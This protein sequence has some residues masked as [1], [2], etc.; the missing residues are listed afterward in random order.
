M[1]FK[2]FI[3]M[4]GAVPFSISYADIDRGKEAY[5]MGEYERAIAEFIPEADR[6]NTYALIKL[7]FMCENGW[8]IAKDFKKA[9]DYYKTAADAGNAEGYMSIAKLYAYGKGVEKNEELAKSNLLRAA[10]LGET[11]AY[12][13]LANTYNDIYAFGEKPLEALKWYLMAAEKNTAA[14]SRNGH[15]NPGIGRWFRLLSPEGVRLTRLSADTGNVYAQFNTG[16]RY[17]YGEGV[18][19]DYNVAEE[20]FF[21]AAEG[22]IVEAQKFVGEAHAMNNPIRTDNVFVDKWFTI[23]SLGGNRAARVFKNSLEDQMSQ[24]EITAAEEAANV[25]LKGR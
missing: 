2:L 10:G 14:F 3:F 24:D 16:L 4:M 15:Y 5:Y 7:G 23:S 20:Y 19:R 11:H 25:W 17:F 8:G 6:G 9:M 13:I 22:G 12:Y 18:V 21:K 1:R